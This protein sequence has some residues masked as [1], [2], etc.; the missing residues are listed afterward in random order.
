MGVP[1]FTGVVA[2]PYPAYTQCAEASDYDSLNQY[3]QAGIAALLA[4]GVA[5]VIVLA[6]GLPWCYL[7]AAELGIWAAGLAYC[8]W[9]LNGRLICLPAEVSATTGPAVDVCAVG[10]FVSADQLQPSAWPYDLPDL[11][12]D[13]C[14]D[15]VL[16]GTEPSKPVDI[17]IGETNA[18][19]NLGLGFENGGQGQTASYILQGVYDGSSAAYQNGGV[20]ITSPVL[21]CE[22]EGA[23]VWDYSNWLL[24]LFWATVAALA[25]QEALATIPVIGPIASV[26][27]SIICAILAF[28][29]SLFGFYSSENDQAN[30]PSGSP[31]STAYPFN[32]PGSASGNPASVVCVVGTWVYDSAHAGWNEIH[33]VMMV[34]PIGVTAPGPDGTYGWNPSWAQQCGMVNQASSPGTRDNQRQPTNSWLIH[35]SVDGCGTY[36]TPPLPPPTPAPPPLQ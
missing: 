13:W 36:P 28:L 27:W 35:P 16:Y 17:L 22:I 11:D 8:H 2:N 25:G 30:Q 1:V 31:G 26:I 29:A 9:W 24:V 18:I 7:L 15:I 33:P 14:M 20:T 5:A 32:A 6:S 19:Q 23:G 3:V 21:H 10:M 12:T 34:Q 4:G